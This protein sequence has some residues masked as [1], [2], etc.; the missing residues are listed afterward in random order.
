[1]AYPLLEI[2]YP[3]PRTGWAQLMQN[4]PDSRIASL[5]IFKIRWTVVNIVLFVHGKCITSNE[6]CINKQITV[7]EIEILLL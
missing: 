2:T 6:N 5:E 7:L 3:A 1:M 4:F